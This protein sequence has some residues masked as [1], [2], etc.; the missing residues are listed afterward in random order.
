MLNNIIDF[1]FKEG[2]KKCINFSGN[3]TLWCYKLKHLDFFTKNSLQRSEQHLLKCCYFEVGNL[4]IIVVHSKNG[5]NIHQS[6][7]E[8]YPNEIE[9]KFLL[10]LDLDIA[11]VKY[12]LGFMINMTSFLSLMYKCKTFTVT[13]H[14]LSFMELYHLI[15]FILQNHLLLF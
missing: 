6:H 8:I 13:F 5:G 9:L 4:T 2:N 3:T 14:D 12:H 11:M 10:F 7:K 1:A 15:S